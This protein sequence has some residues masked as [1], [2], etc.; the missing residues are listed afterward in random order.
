MSN[1]NGRYKGEWIND[2][3]ALFEF[4]INEN[5]MVPGVGLVISGVIV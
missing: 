4:D 5:F 1:I 2:R 3:N